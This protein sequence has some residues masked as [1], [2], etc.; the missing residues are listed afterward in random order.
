MLLVC[1]QC[2]SGLQVPDGTTA[3]VR[4]PACQ[5]VFA[6]TASVAAGDEEPPRSAKRRLPPAADASPRRQ[7]T[8]PTTPPP[9]RH[10][11]I[12]P[13]AEDDDRP[14]K[15]KKRRVE[16]DRSLTA[17]EKAAKRAAFRRAAGGATLICVAFACFILSMLFIIVYF[18]HSAFAEPSPGWIVAAGF[19]GV[20]HWL[21]SAVGLGLCVSGPPSPGHWG[22]SIAAI[23]VVAIHSFLVMALMI[24][25]SEFAVVNDNSG[26]PLSWGYIP[27]R[28]NATMFFLTSVVYPD[29][30]GITPRGRMTLSMITGA[31][32]MLRA[33]LILMVLSGLARAAL[34]DELAQRCTRAAGVVS[35]GPALISLLIFAFVTTVVETHAG[36]NLFTR[37][38]LDTVQ[39]GVY[40]ILIGVIF[41]ALMAARDV[42]DA[43]NE[44]YQSLA[45]QL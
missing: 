44:P 10:R 28:L 4:C 6:P 9:A 30:Q 29:E 27:T 34:D 15:R 19:F 45:P 5:T 1:P 3:L 31:V 17:E 24:Q 22:Y 11:D 33:V 35:I 14:L 40:A 21:L 39:M 8:R 41:P 36:M 23:V 32:E 18:F 13:I 37:I 7:D 26:E 20:F 43:C 42:V 16:A 2:H 25:G 12:D 38:L